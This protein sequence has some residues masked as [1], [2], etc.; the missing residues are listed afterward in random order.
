MRVNLKKELG[1]AL[2]EVKNS[3]WF[4]EL[5]KETQA[6]ALEQQKNY[7]TPPRDEAHFFLNSFVENHCKDEW[8]EYMKQNLP[9][10][11]TGNEGGDVA[12]HKNQF[13]QPYLL[14]IV[15]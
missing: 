4:K 5:D 1:L 3:N 14:N 11:E 6:I 10:A 2:G 8:L 13:V 9:W 7:Y 12:W 15:A